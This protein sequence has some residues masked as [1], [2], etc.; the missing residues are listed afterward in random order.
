MSCPWLL[1]RKRS[2]LIHMSAG[3]PNFTHQ[4]FQ[5]PGTTH[6]SEVSEAMIEVCS[7]QEKQ[8]FYFFNE[9]LIHFV[10]IQFSL[11]SSL[12]DWCISRAVQTRLSML[13][14]IHANSFSLGCSLGQGLPMTCRVLLITSF[15]AACLQH[16][17][18]LVLHA[19]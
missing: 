4:L 2:M 15:F 14:H 19:K 11:N 6:A 3:S 12:E 5:P 9:Q 7:N 13:E 1:P 16:I 18:V 10:F 8:D 17:P